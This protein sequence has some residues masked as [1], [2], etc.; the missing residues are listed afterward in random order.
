MGKTIVLLLIAVGSLSC[1]PSHP[2]TEH[3]PAEVEQTLREM[4]RAFERYDFEALSA[5]CADSFVLIENSYPMSYGKTVDMM[6]G[7]R[8]LGL[9]ISYELGD[10]SVEIDGNVAWAIYTNTG[11]Y[12]GAS[13]EAK[14][15]IHTVGFDDPFQLNFVETAVLRHVEGQWKVMLLHATFIP[16][17]TAITLMESLVA[18]N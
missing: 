4:E 11:T 18:Q 1:R 2:S 7:F 17:E 13:E 6:T 16:S 3:S 8:D 14:N 5:V 15:W 9:G 10:F 12:S